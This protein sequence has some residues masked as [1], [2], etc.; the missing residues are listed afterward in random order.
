MVIIDFTLGK[1]AFCHKRYSLLPDSRPIVLFILKQSRT[2]SLK[3]ALQPAEDF[4]GNVKKKKRLY[5][6]ISYSD[7]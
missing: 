6:L 7:A 5:F 2:D 1:F 4:S 3:S